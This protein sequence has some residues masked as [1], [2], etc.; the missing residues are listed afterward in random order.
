[1]FAGRGDVPSR[2]LTKTHM[3]KMSS[4]NREGPPPEKVRKIE[5]SEHDGGF[6]F[7]TKCIAFSLSVNFY[8]Q[9]FCV[10]YK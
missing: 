2:R 7:S 9:L 8:F 1:M 5:P 6:K 10:L 3:E 4:T